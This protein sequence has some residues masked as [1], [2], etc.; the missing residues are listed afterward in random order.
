MAA[1]V[2][3]FLSLFILL[4][5]FV[6]LRAGSFFRD[7]AS[8]DLSQLPLSVL[9]LRLLYTLFLVWSVLLA[10]A[11]SIALGSMFHWWSK[12]KPVVAAPL[13]LSR[14]L[15]VGAYLFFLS[16]F[17]VFTHATEVCF[18][19]NAHA[20]Y[21][22]HSRACACEVNSTWQQ[23]QLPP[24]AGTCA[25][26][27][28]HVCRPPNAGTGGSMSNARK[29]RCRACGLDSAMFY[30]VGNQVHLLQLCV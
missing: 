17:L 29:Q 16:F 7:E 9:L 28:Y 14:V 10:V 27:R 23:S 11:S 5:V 21:I 25:P 22:A 19:F 2:V 13:A 24:E 3:Q 8:A 26:K 30:Q 18:R 20:D 12:G 1:G 4:P 6:S 15:R